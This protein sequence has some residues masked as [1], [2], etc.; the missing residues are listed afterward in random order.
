MADA[1]TSFLRAE[2]NGPI[3]PNRVIV[4]TVLVV[5]GSLLGLA[6]FGGGGSD[7]AYHVT[8]TTTRGG[9]ASGGQRGVVVTVVQGRPT[10]PESPAVAPP[11]SVEETPV[12]VESPASGDAKAPPRAAPSSSSSS[13][14]GSTVRTARSLLPHEATGETVS[15]T[16]TYATKWKDPGDLGWR[17]LSRRAGEACASCESAVKAVQA[18]HDDGSKRYGGFKHSPHY[19]M[20]WYYHD[21]PAPVCGMALLWHLQS[22]PK[23][24]FTLRA[25]AARLRS[26]DPAAAAS[27][28][29]GSSDHACGASGKDLA[30]LP[31]KDIPETNANVANPGHRAPDDMVI[32]GA[33]DDETETIYA[34]VGETVADVLIE[35][36]GTCGSGAGSSFK[37]ESD[38]DCA[39]FSDVLVTARLVGANGFIAATVEQV[40]S[41]DSNRRGQRRVSFD[42]TLPGVFALEVKVVHSLGTSD[43]P[44]KPRSL[45]V[46]GIRAVESGRKS[47]KYNTKC[48]EQRHVFG[49]PMRV[50]V[51][52]AS[53]MSRPAIAALPSAAT[54]ATPVPPFCSAANHT[55]GR[56]VRFAGGAK[57]CA[58]RNNPFCFGNA[59]WLTDAAAYNTDFLWAPTSCRYV[60][61]DAPQGPA[62]SCLSV[63]E[64]SRVFLLLVG[65]S[66]TR[67]YTK[68]CLQFDLRK[69]RLHCLFANIA[70]E[71]QH[72]STDYAR[73]VARVVVENIKTNN[74][75]VF[76]TNLGIHHMIGPCTTAQWREFVQLFVEEWKKDVVWNPAA[77]GGA[78]VAATPAS[79]SV[80]LEKQPFPN[81]YPKGTTVAKLERAIWIGPPTIHY[82][83]KGMGSQRAV[84]WDRIAWELL[85]P[86]GFERVRA[87]PPTS[88][89]QEGTWDGLHYASERNKVQTRWRN[90]DATPRQ[91]NGGVAN[92]LFTML[93]NLVCYGGPNA[94]G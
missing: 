34:R 37:P 33:I 11:T 25:P 76:A 54:A 46:I 93:L 3:K 60:F 16:Y 36:C 23:H 19:K 22:G 14:S 94:A 65:D 5:A 47:F 55:V 81:Q 92:M 67:E 72:Y 43:D 24:V 4:L 18:V 40:R 35:D 30:A 31:T 66:V 56:W 70:L 7:D 63:P 59:N 88:P 74:A 83:R 1:A 51:L 85:E 89:R 64:S 26:A 2:A 68:N 21:N 20:P 61:F 77:H 52:P 69:S 32:G 27:S 49:S 82:A 90:R 71:G 6:S 87:V 17:K 45:G 9:A 8:S 75:G 58:D 28:S 91:W 50:V 41:S 44:A 15:L 42:A 13:S 48:D 53:A 80:N 62:G 73:S 84:L 38:A 86:L 79:R 39:A 29:S 10:S 78:M 57:S 12:T